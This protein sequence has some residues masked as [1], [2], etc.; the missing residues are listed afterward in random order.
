MQ[1]RRLHRLGRFRRNKRRL[2]ERLRQRIFFRDR[3]MTPEVMNKP[4]V[5]VLTGAGI[6]AESGIR[7]FRAADG[8]WEE[9]RVEDVATPEGF[10]RNP[11]LVQKFYNARRRQLQ[12]PEIKP[13]AAHLALARLEEALGDRFLLVTQ[14]IDNLHERAGSKN[15]VHMH[16]ELLKVRCSQSGQVL[17]W[18]G[19]VTPGDKCHCCQFPAPLRPHVVWFGEM[20]LGMDSIYEALARADVFIA[21]GTSGHVYPAAGFVHEAKLQGAHTVE[22]NLEPSQVGSEFEEKHYG[23]ASQV[24]PEYVEKLLKGL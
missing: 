24:V 2:R 7:T 14:N 21:I 8:L 11:Q 6:S 10:A 15:V 16:G 22:L 3:I 5:V 4:V 17:E 20:P 23:L 18:T 12:Q 9:H 19:D 13:N 1:S